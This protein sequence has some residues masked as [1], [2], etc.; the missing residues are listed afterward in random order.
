[1][2]KHFEYKPHG[3]CSS[4]IEYDY[5]DGKVYNVRFTNGCRGNTQGVARLAEGMEAEEIVRRT[6]GI[7]CRNNT[8][9]PNE[10]AKAIEAG[11][12]EMNNAA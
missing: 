6:K 8:S 11:L 3:V 1:M 7:I 5:E 4:K 2:T 9:C 12:K 10:L